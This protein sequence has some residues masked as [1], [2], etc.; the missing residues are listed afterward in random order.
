MTIFL[1]SNVSFLNPCY[2]GNVDTYVTIKQL[3]KKAFTI[4]SQNIDQE[5]DIQ[6]TFILQIKLQKYIFYQSTTI[7]LANYASISKPC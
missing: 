2:D 7:L 4:N 3:K 1:V 5:I 6:V